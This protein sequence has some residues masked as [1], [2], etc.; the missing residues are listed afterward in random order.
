MCFISNIDTWQALKDRQR[1]L[2]NTSDVG[3]YD[4]FGR[5]S[6]MMTP[7]YDWARIQD[8]HAFLWSLKIPFMLLSIASLVFLFIN[9]IMI[10]VN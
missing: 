5:N 1:Q 6:A 7:V 3:P 9:L 8:G 10:I 2:A 4:R